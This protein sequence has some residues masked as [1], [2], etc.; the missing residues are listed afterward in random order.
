MAPPET[1]ADGST[2]LPAPARVLKQAEQLAAN[3]DRARA[4]LE[5]ARLKAERS[6]AAMED[7]WDYLHALIRMLRAYFGRTYREVPWHTIA[8]GL[9]ALVYFVAPLDFIPDILLGGLAD[10]AAVVLFVARQ[11]QKDLDVFLQWESSSAFRESG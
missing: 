9:A 7:V 10:D 3:P 6:R 8:W 4:L 11:I 5:S 1:S 2:L